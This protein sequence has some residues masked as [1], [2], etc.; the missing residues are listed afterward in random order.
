MFV[1]IAMIST[2]GLVSNL[3]FSALERRFSGWRPGLREV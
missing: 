3:F 1:A 2:A